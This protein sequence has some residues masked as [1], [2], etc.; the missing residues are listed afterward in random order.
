MGLRE[1][2]KEA[3]RSMMTVKYDGEDYQFDMEDI[4]VGQART[5]KT[6]FDVTMGNLGEK[7]GDQ[8]PDA[9]T[10]VYW[11]MMV[12]NDNP[13]PIDQIDFKIIKFANAL[14]EAFSESEK[15]ADAKAKA[16]GRKPRPK[17]A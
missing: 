6:V 1:A 15:A 17:A 7:L 10:A 9:M 8:D 12:Q 2:T 13:V 16:A 5:L 4:T 3:K 14:N 11:L